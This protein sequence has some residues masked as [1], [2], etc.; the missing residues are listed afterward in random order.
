MWSLILCTPCFISEL[1][2]L[3]LTGPYLFLS[4][5]LQGYFC[6]SFVSL[7]KLHDY[8]FW[9]VVF[10]CCLSYRLIFGCLHVFC[11]M[12]LFILLIPDI[13]STRL[14]TRDIFMVLYTPFTGYF[15]VLNIHIKLFFI[16]L[17]LVPDIYGYMYTPLTGLFTLFTGYFYASLY[18]NCIG[19]VYASLNEPVWPNGKQ[20]DL[21]SNQPRLSILFKSCGL[22]TLSC[23]FVPHN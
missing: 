15:T 8:S 13:F 4:E 12:I 22:W 6:V 19:Y 23:D 11:I 3:Q 18:T 5:L 16:H 17:V 1:F 10:E 9:L 2:V 14:M 7:Y 21:G 20:R